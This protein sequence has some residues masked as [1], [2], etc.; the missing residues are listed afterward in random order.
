MWPERCSPLEALARE[1]AQIRVLFRRFEYPT[2]PPR[3]PG[4]SVVSQS[5]MTAVPGWSMVRAQ[6]TA[7]S[8][9]RSQGGGVRGGDHRCV[10][11]G[12]GVVVLSRADHTDTHVYAPDLWRLDGF[13]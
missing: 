1:A 10:P 6:V 12:A 2:L 8:E 9:R 5:M 13:R 11:L 4:R 7:W 3:T